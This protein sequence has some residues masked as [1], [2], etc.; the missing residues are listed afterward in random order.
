MHPF[1]KTA[2]FEVDDFNL[3]CGLA[4]PQANYLMFMIEIC[5]DFCQEDIF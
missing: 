3:T 5:T 4:V 2:Q 1:V